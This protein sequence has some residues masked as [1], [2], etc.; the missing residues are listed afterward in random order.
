MV[1]SNDD[2]EVVRARLA[3]S[4]VRVDSQ[5]HDEQSHDVWEMWTAQMMRQRAWLHEVTSVVLAKPDPAVTA[6]TLDALGTHAMLRGDHAAAAEYFLDAAR[7]AIT[8]SGAT[9]LILKAIEQADAY[10]QQLR[11]EES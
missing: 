1:I 3:V 7:L 11:P 8:H 9:E 10:A 5:Q 4:D 2:T 6:F